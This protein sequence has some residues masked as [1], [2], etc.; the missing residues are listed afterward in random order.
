ILLA[1]VQDKANKMC[2]PYFCNGM[3]ATCPTSCPNGD[4]DCY[5]GY[6]CEVSAMPP[7]C[8]M[9]KPLGTACTAGYQCAG[10]KYCTD[11]TCCDTAPAQCA[12]AGK[13]C[14]NAMGKCM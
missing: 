10:A 13:K 2:S 11:M 14:N 8:Q 9:Q 3:I 5:N 4:N 7:T 6:F 12:A 1:G